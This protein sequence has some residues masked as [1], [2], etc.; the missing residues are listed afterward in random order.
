[1]AMQVRTSAPPRS[2]DLPVLSST[3]LFTKPTCYMGIIRKSRYK[4][5]LGMLN[6]PVRSLDEYCEALWLKEKKQK[7]KGKWKHVQ[8]LRKS[9]NRRHH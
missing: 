9:R 1:V 5:Y 6:G 3:S 8:E 2:T 4:D 7:Q